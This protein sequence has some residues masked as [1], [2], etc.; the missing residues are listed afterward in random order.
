[1]FSVAE[2]EE[3]NATSVSEYEKR[4]KYELCKKYEYTLDS[5]PDGMPIKQVEHHLE[6]DDLV[7]P[8]CSNTMTEIGKEIVRTL[9]IIPTQMVVR[10]D[11]YY[12]YACR[13]YN[14]KDT[15]TPPC[16]GSQGKEH[17]S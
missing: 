8:R 5:I 4:K 2:K 16:K 7:C 14:K 11:I 12:T 10:E 15:Q 9:K 6:G 13:V 3:E 17:Y 1:M